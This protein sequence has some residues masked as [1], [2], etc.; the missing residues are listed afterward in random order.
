LA[1]HPELPLALLE[2]LAHRLQ[3]VQERSVPALRLRDRQRFSV[4]I[5]QVCFCA[6]ETRKQGRWE[7]GHLLGAHDMYKSNWT[8][9][10]IALA[11]LASDLDKDCLSNAVKLTL[12]DFRGHGDDVRAG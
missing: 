2:A 11:Y 7:Y 6:A 10:R 3:F 4:S 9:L 8:F 5:V 1:S 12:I